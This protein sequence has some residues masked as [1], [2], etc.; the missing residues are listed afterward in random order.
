MRRISYSQIEKARKS[1][2]KKIFL[3]FTSEKLFFF[4]IF[5]TN[6]CLFAALVSIM[7]NYCYTLIFLQANFGFMEKLQRKIIEIF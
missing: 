1:S 6:T 3:K 4:E 2:L 7:Q 5:L